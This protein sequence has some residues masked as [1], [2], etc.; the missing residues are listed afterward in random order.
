MRFP[1]WVPTPQE[2][3]LLET[4]IGVSQITIIFLNGIF[5]G[6]VFAMDFT[7]FYSNS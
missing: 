3:I 7:T 4:K 6:E 1:S 5:F 2:Q